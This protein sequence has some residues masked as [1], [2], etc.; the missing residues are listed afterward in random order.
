MD[1]N[2]IDIVLQQFQNVKREELLTLASILLDYWDNKCPESLTS[3]RADVDKWC[4]N[5]LPFLCCYLKAH[6]E[7][8]KSEEFFNLLCKVENYE[9]ISGNLRIMGLKVIGTDI[10]LDECS[11]VIPDENAEFHNLGIPIY[12]EWWNY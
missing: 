2:E 9:Y 7:I 3:L 10:K 12:E 4:S 6:K 5:P 1:M 11:E 8:A